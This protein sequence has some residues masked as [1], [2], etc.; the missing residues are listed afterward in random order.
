MRV[1]FSMAR[2]YCEKCFFWAMVEVYL[3]AFA[4]ILMIVTSLMLAGLAT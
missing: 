2:K 3:K 4:V 1:P